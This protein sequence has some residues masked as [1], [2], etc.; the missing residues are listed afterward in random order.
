MVDECCSSCGI[1]SCDSCRIFGDRL[2]KK[3][4]EDA[5]E[6][7][8]WRCYGQKKIVKGGVT[9]SRKYY[10]CLRCKTFGKFTRRVCRDTYPN[11]KVHWH[12]LV[13][14]VLAPCV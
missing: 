14:S 10:K 9:I 2:P 13:G 1:P 11:K 5:M 4:I 7:H 3:E 8:M 12:P 6:T